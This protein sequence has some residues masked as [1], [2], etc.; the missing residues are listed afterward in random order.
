MVSAAYMC[1]LYLGAWVVTL[2][3]PWLVPACQKAKFHRGGPHAGLLAQ[4]LT[5]VLQCNKINLVATP[6]SH[7]R[8]SI[9]LQDGLRAK[10]TSVR[11]NPSHHIILHGWRCF[12][13]SSG[14]GLVN[15]QRCQRVLRCVRDATPCHAHVC[16]CDRLCLCARVQKRVGNARRAT[17]STRM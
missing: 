2:P 14:I 5:L 16:H 4:M 13:I 3:A 10:D 7:L 1:I 6:L 12:S 11:S 17:P 8:V 15:T 9:L